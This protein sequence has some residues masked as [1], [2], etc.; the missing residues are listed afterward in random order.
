MRTKHSAVAGKVSF[1][2]EAPEHDGAAGT[3]PKG[4]QGLC[5]VCAGAKNFQALLFAVV[6]Q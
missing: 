3:Q 4:A 6:W 5:C 2:L 1:G